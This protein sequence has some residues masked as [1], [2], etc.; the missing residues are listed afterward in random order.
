MTRKKKNEPINDF[1]ISD[2]VNNI[3]GNRIRFKAKNRAQKEFAKLI[4]EKEIVISAGPAGTGKSFVS[5][6]RALELLQNKNNK[7][8]KILIYKPAIEVE[9][10]HGFLPGDLEE[11]IAPYVES[12]LSLI[13]KLIGKPARE[14]MIMEDIIEIK[15]LAYIRGTNI[16]NS[17]L[18]M[19]EAQNMSPN[20]MKTLLSRIGENSKFIISGDMDQSDRYRDVKKSGLYDAMNR[21]RKV[22]EIG[23]FEFKHED[24]VRNPIIGKILKYYNSPKIGDDSPKEENDKRVIPSLPDSERSKLNE[25]SSKKNKNNFQKKSWWELIP[26]YF[27]W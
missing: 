6:A 19:E 16:D 14:R 12:S 27:R 1:T 5:I 3:V 7:F 23:F 21:L 25:N 13:D 11:K 9:E 4:T 24:I 26:K 10:K 17:I 22:E 2:I 18:I 8:E 20:Q 15:A